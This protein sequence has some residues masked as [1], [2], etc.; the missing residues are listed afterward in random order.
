MID[1][2]YETVIST[3]V[4]RLYHYKRFVP[5]HLDALLMDDAIYF[6]KPTEFNDPWDCK[7]WFKIPDDA[8][9]RAQLVRWFD[10]ANRRR[11]LPIDEKLRERQ[12]RC[13]IDNPALLGETMEKLSQQI[14]TNLGDVYRLYCLSLKPGCPLGSLRGQAPRNLP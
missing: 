14:G 3:G 9:G 12:M 5:E 11:G 6:S 13:L 10:T 2:P 7:P 4:R 8:A 1:Q